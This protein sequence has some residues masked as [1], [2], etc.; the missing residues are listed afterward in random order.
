M[1]T[2]G[3]IT[4]SASELDTLLEKAAQ[5]G[6]EKALEELGLEKPA[7]RD[8]LKEA[9]ELAKIWRRTKASVWDTT[10]KML[11]AAV[12]GAL[13]LGMAVGLVKQIP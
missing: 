13:A 12:L 10:V 1:T 7:D 9:L 4:I 3:G 11:T 2:I 5:R 8:D 6:A